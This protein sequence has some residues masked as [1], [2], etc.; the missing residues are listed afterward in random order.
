[1][2]EGRGTRASDILAGSEISAE[3]IRTMITA[4]RFDAA[5]RPRP[6]H[7]EDGS[8]GAF[9]AMAPATN[10]KADSTTL[11]RGLIVAR[12]DVDKSFSDYGL[13]AGTN[14]LWV[15]RLGPAEQ[16]WRAIVVSANGRDRR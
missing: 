16:P 7:N 4:A 15:D 2:A 11:A 8:I 1:M 10:S 9:A 12:I 13:S 5:G 14:Y 3:A 6:L